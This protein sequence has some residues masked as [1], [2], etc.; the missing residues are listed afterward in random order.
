M[1]RVETLLSSFSCRISELDF[2]VAHAASNFITSDLH[3]PHL[4]QIK[5]GKRH[6]NDS[7]TTSDLKMESGAVHSTD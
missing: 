5:Y 4:P 1:S 2:F 7:L 6:I 3:V